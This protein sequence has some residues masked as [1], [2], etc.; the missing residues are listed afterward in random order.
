MDPQLNLDAILKFETLHQFQFQRNNQGLANSISGVETDSV[1][2]N[3]E[4]YSIS[5]R[6]NVLRNDK[7]GSFTIALSG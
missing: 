4:P 6:E 2:N 7:T 3:P 1:N 5:K